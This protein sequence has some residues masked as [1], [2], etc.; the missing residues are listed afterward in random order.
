[1]TVIKGGFISVFPQDLASLS[2]MRT[3]N[4]TDRSGNVLIVTAVNR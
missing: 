4:N 1:M 3:G 2:S